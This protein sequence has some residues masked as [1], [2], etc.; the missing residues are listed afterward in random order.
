MGRLFQDLLRED[1]WREAQRKPM[2]I[3]PRKDS[4]SIIRIM[5]YETMFYDWPAL[6]PSYPVLQI[7]NRRA[8]GL[9][10]WVVQFLLCHLQA[11]PQ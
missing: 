6:A 8:S 7:G 5:S 9:E 10:D 4:P 2:E 1:Y 3:Q 11:C